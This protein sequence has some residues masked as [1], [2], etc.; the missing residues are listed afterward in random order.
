MTDVAISWIINNFQPV[1]IL[2]AVGYLLAFAVTFVTT[3][4]LYAAVIMFRNMR[5]DGRLEGLSP[6]VIVIIKAI[7]YLGLLLDGIL[8][9]VF[10]TVYFWEW[11]KEL[12]CTARVKR[13]YWSKQDTRNKRKAVWFAK[14]FLLPVDPTHMGTGA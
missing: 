10:L 7:L 11:P 13:W 9:I 2:Y 12:T 4:A 8:D 3:F 1:Y 6:V 5:D 14:N